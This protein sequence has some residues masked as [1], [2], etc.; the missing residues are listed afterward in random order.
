MRLE[1]WIPLVVALATAGVGLLVWLFQKQREHDDQIRQ[2]KQ[3]LY[4]SVSSKR[5][6]GV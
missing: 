5:S 2:R 1:T 4:E 6:P 3:A